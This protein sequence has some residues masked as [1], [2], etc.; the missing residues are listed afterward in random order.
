LEQILVKTLLGLGDAVYAWS[1]VRWLIEN[2]SNKEILVMTS[3]PIIFRNLKCKTVPMETGRTPDYHLSYTTRRNSPK[4]QY[5]D[6]LDQCKFPWID[7]EFIFDPEKEDIVPILDFKEYAVIKE[8]A[9]AHLHKKTS[10]YSFAPNIEEMQDYVYSLNKK[11]IGVISVGQN[12]VFKERLSGIDVDLN[13][14]LTVGQLLYL[15]SKSV[16]VGT[17]VGHLLPIAQGLGKPCRIFM[18]EKITDHR[19]SSFGH[20]K[21]SVE[22]YV[23]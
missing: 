18:P 10:D 20:H 3:Y 6:I 22:K 21:L 23:G 15:C 12:E 2:N 8:P 7:F 11:G 9:T 5:E 17:Q 14:K 1:I 16:E 13:D 4:G 19:F